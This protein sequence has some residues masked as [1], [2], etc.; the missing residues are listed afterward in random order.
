[1]ITGFK[2]QRKKKNAGEKKIERAN[3]NDTLM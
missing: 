2:D 1:M 3:D